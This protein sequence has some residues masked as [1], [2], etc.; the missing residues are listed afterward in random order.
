MTDKIVASYRENARQIIYYLTNSAPG[1]NMNGV[2]DFKTG[3]G[4][5][6]VNDYILEGEVADPGLQKLASDNFF[7]T[8]LSENY[9]NSLGVFCEANCFCSPDLHPFNDDD[10]SPRTQANRGCFH[11][12]NNGIPQQKARETC[13]KEGAALVSIHDALKEFFVNGV[14]SIFGPKKKFWLGYQNDGTQWIWDDKSTDPY[15]DWDNKQPNTNGGKN[16]CAYA[17][18]TFYMHITFHYCS[19]L[20]CTQLDQPTTQFVMKIHSTR[21]SQVYKDYSSPRYC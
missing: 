4:I 19:P 14:V 15:T 1:A 16:M 17:T 7:F 8:D 9:I 21:C 20:Q 5:I 18:S 12:V 6:I 3:G 11:P 10:N 2:D 13:Q